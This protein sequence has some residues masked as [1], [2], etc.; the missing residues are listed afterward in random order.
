VTQKF[1]LYI[2]VSNYTKKRLVEYG[3]PAEKIMVAHN[4]VDAEIWVDEVPIMDEV[5]NILASNIIP[6]GTINNLDFIR[7]H[8]VLSASTRENE[9]VNTIDRFSGLDIASTVFTKIDE[10]SSLGILLN[11]QLQNPAPLSYITNGQKVPE[12][13]LHINPRLVAKL[14]MAH[15]EGSPNE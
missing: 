8:L 1:D 2:A 14:I 3:V 9:L 4:G 11:V 7:K 6:G 12:D 5:K 15:D 10:C 13:L